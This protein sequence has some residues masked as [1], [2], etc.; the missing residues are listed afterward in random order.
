LFDQSI[1]RGLLIGLYFPVHLTTSREIV[2][3][4]RF[5]RG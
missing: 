3:A 5:T 4:K 1:T 2:A